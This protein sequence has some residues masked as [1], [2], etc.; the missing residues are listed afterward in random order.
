MKKTFTL[1]FSFIICALAQGNHAN[2]ASQQQM[3]FHCQN[4][5][6]E[7]NQLL[8]DGS[9]SG[10]KKPNE[11]MTFYAHKLIGRPYVA[12]TLEGDTEKQLAAAIGS[13]T[14]DFIASKAQ[15]E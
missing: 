1:I 4:D 9:K 7:I 6:T 15:G 5:T 2:A 14:Q 8:A 11:L 3:R 13:F 10:L 12:H